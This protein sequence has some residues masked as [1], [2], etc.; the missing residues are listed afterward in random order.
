[1]FSRYFPGV[2]TSCPSFGAVTPVESSYVEIDC[3]FLVEMTM[4]RGVPLPFQTNQLE[5][6]SKN[7]A[8]KSN[9][10][11]FPHF[12]SGHTFGCIR[13]TSLQFFF[14]QSL[15]HFSEVLPLGWSMWQS[16]V[17]MDPFLGVWLWIWRFPKMAVPQVRWMIYVMENPNLKWMIKNRALALFF[18]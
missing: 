15:H 8:G 11:H 2:Q 4:D 16:L 17:D 6:N 9:Y 1:M 10:L 3:L 7:G 18:F 12:S 5:K 14:F 13:W